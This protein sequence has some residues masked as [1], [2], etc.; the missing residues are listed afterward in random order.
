MIKYCG[1]D[2][3]SFNMLNIGGE[4]VEL[5]GLGQAFLDVM[6]L[7]LA[8]DEA[9]EKLLENVGLKNYIPVCAENEYRLALLA[10]YKNFIAEN[11]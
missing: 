4:L 1:C 2:A 7:D 3:G 8:G 5:A 11:R 6:G 9:A 10:E